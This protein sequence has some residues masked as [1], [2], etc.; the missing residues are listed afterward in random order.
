MK[1]TCSGQ[2]RVGGGGSPEPP[3]IRNLALD[4][5]PPMLWETDTDKLGTESARES[6]G[7]IYGFSYRECLHLSRGWGRRS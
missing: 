3:S 6:F 4:S 1:E 7:G 5:L 2:D